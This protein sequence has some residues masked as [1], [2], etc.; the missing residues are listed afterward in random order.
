MIKCLTINSVLV[1]HVLILL[2]LLISTSFLL[3]HIPE[4][5][6]EDFIEDFKKYF[7]ESEYARTHI[8][9]IEGKTYYTVTS[10]TIIFKKMSN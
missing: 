5:K 6:K 9:Q 3:P 4:N 8:K 10:Y 7:R 1:N 2:D